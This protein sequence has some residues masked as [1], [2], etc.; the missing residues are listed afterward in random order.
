MLPTKSQAMKWLVYYIKSD[1]FH[2][3]SCHDQCSDLL[4]YVS[5]CHQKSDVASGETAV[6]RASMRNA[7]VDGYLR[8][9]PGVQRRLSASLKVS[10]PALITKYKCK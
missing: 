4:H 5:F 9:L 8:V 1:D 3:F 10:R 6:A 2:W 7:I